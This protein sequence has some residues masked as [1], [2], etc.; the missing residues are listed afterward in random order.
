PLWPSLMGEL[1]PARLR[2]R[3]FGARARLMHLANLLAL[4]AGGL[5]LQ[6]FERHDDAQFAFTL[7]F[8]GAA[9]ARLCS[10]YHL[11]RTD[12]TK[13]PAASQ[14]LSTASRRLDPRFVRFAAFSAA[15]AL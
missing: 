11:A 6:F 13:R 12:S 14:P 3:F 5:A 15:M 10:V 7:L 8:T 4:L 1:V 9:V 2:G